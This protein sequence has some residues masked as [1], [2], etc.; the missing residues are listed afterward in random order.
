MGSEND[1]H[2]NEKILVIY[3]RADFDGIFCR[4]IAKRFLGDKAEYLGWDYGDAVPDPTVLPADRPVYMLDISIDGLMGHPLLIWIDHHKT[5]IECRTPSI[6][7]YQIDGVAACRL[8]WQYF[9]TDSRNPLT[10]ALPGKQDFIDRKVDEPYAVQLAGEYDIWDKRNP[11]AELFQHGLRS[12]ELVEFDWQQMLSVYRPTITEIEQWI[13]AGHTNMLHPDGTA[14]PPTVYGLLDAGRAIQYSKTKENEGI[15]RAFGFTIQ[16]E[17]FTLLA[18]NTARYNSQLFAAGLKPEHDGCFGFNWDGQKKEWRVSLYSD[19]P[20]ID[21]SV[22]A[23]K[24]GGGGHRGACGF[25]C[26]QLPFAL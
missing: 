19:K 10:F 20:G 13:D 5:A 21:L 12:R 3:H 1:K 26:T 6:P 15:I 8:T 7:G 11:E 17:G 23:M 18:C 24:Y 4:E 2:M 22:V 25:R 16:F 9:A 14:T